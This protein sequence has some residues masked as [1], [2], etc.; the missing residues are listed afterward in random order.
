MD[1][2]MVFSYNY[3]K[4]KKGRQ[5]TNAPLLRAILMAMQAR[6]SGTDRITQCGMSR[7]TLEAT[8]CHHRA[9]TCSLMPQQPP[10]QQQTKLWQKVWTNF[11]GHFDGCSGAP[12]G[13]CMHCLMEEAHDFDRSHWTPPLGKYSANTCNQSHTWWFFFSFYIVNS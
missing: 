6:C 8:G 12:V 13:Y 4:Q 3:G 9:T 7:A 5:K 11:A 2:N 10:G 1:H